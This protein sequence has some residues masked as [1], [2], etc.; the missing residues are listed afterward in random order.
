MSQ[1]FVGEVKFVSFNFAPRGYAACNGQ[2]LASNQNQALFSLLGT[3][4]GGDGRTTFGLPNLQG[5]AA[6]HWGS[7]PSGGISSVTWGQVGG[8]QAHTLA[9]TEMA[10]HNHALNASNQGL[11]LNTPV[12]NYVAGSNAGAY[13]TSSNAVMTGNETGTIGGQAHNNMQPYLTVTAIIAL[14]GIFPSRN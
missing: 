9:I 10:A 2:L 13:A 1:P 7:T 4:Y 14:V 3:T 5:T 12:N 6:V 8:E 11:S